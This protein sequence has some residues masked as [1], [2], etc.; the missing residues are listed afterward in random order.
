MIKHLKPHSKFRVWY[1]KIKGFFFKDKK[2][3]IIDPF[4]PFI[5]FVRNDVSIGYN[6]ISVQPMNKPNGQLFYLDYVYSPIIMVN[7][8]TS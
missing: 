2:S 7:Y 4:I 1:Y 6:L 3:A 5:P 8:E